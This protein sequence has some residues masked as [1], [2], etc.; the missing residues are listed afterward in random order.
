[1]SPKYP[2]LFF[3][4]ITKITASGGKDDVDESDT[5]TALNPRKFLTIHHK[6]AESGT[7]R[8][9]VKF[10]QDDVRSDMQKYAIGTADLV[11]EGM[12][13]ASLNHPNII[14]V[15]ALP[16]GGVMSL[17]KKENR[18][19]GYFLV[20]DRLFNTLGD[21]IYKVWS[22]F[23][24]Q[25]GHCVV[26]KKKFGLFTSK[27]DVKKRDEDLA[28]RLK[29]ALD[30]SAALKYLHSKN[31]IYRDL[32]PEN[33][34]FDG[35]MLMHFRCLNLSFILD[36]SS[37]IIRAPFVQQMKV[38]GDIKLFDLGLVK[39]L[40]PKEKDIHGNYNLSLAGTPRYMSPECAMHQ[41]YNLSADV[42][43]FSMLLWEILTLEKPMKNFSYAQLK[44]EI[45][46][47]GG[48]PPLKHV[49]DKKMRDVISSGWSQVAKE[50]PSM[51][52]IYQE[53]KNKYLHITKGEVS[54][55]V[56]THD[57]RRS[58][59]VAKTRTVSL[60]HLMSVD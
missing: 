16:E 36:H 48:R 26:V 51:E 11:L 4:E 41:P 27:K 58:T 12:F 33:L 42:Y 15:R 7:Y 44:L 59:H 9:A 31:I 57:R 1:M 10:L 29:V 2:L 22:P 37:L 38:R 53:L 14:K 3:S 32:K 35:K 60:R 43:S 19:R 40:H 18:N 47:E 17:L 21:Q 30:L 50:R 13:L 5:D 55:G 56:V 28:V 34:G 25:G 52:D 49:A 45:F 24:Q 54:E 6:R 8:Y 20:L 46:I 23:N 39:E